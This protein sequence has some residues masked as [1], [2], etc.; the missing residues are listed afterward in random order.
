MGILRV[1]STFIDLLV[2]LL[3]KVVPTYMRTLIRIFWL[4]SGIGRKELNKL[5]RL[6]DG[7]FQIVHKFFK[8]C[9]N[10][11]ICIVLSQ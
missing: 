10:F 1:F 9:I 7:R 4:P 3:G 2:K 6:M 5:K 8:Y 11:K